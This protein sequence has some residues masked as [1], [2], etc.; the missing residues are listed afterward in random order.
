MLG[1]VEG[2]T[3]ICAACGRESPA[4]AAFCAACGAPLRR[5][6]ANELEE[7][8]LVTASSLPDSSPA[9]AF[10]RSVGAS[11]LVRRAEALLAASA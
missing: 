6:P 2:D 7:R 9:L 11:V 4:D 1:P 5:A 8:K 10:Y 3:L